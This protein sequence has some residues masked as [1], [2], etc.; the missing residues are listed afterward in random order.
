LRANRKTKIWKQL[1]VSWK[2]GR[3]TNCKIV[4]MYIVYIYIYIYQIDIQTYINVNRDRKNFRIHYSVIC[5][6][7]LLINCYDFLN[8]MLRMQRHRKTRR[9]VR[10]VVVELDCRA[11]SL[12]VSTSWYLLYQLRRFCHVY[13]IN[14]VQWESAMFDLYSRILE[15]SFFLLGFL[16][17]RIH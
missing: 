6:W 14:K 12:F 3:I 2:N 13:K 9:C 16:D 10:N 17:I 4:Y 1:P 15:S 5:W 7:V 11:R 8:H